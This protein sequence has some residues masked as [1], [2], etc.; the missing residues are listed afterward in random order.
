MATLREAESCEG[1]HG[2]GDDQVD[3]LGSHCLFVAN[4]K[5]RYLV[6]KEFV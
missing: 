2:D 6:L 4:V 5:L 3:G 1:E